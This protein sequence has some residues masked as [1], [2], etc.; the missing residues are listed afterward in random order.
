MISVVT[1]VL[2]LPV[3][4]KEDDVKVVGYGRLSDRLPGG[5]NLHIRNGHVGK[6]KPLIIIDEWSRQRDDAIDKLNPNIIESISVLKDESSSVKLYGEEK[7]GVI[8]IT[9][10]KCIQRR[11]EMM[12]TPF[13]SGGFCR[14]SFSLPPAMKV[15]QR[16]EKITVIPVEL[17]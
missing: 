13:I 17:P 4:I 1:K 14:L 5:I 7:D 2:L 9:N 12:K 15:R 10:E 6:E 16:M 8:L 3:K 11:S